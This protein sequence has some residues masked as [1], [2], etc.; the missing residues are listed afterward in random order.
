MEPRKPAGSKRKSATPRSSQKSRRASPSPKRKAVATPDSPPVDLGVGDLPPATERDLQRLA[1]AVEEDD[2]SERAHLA[3]QRR[4]K[5]CL[6]LLDLG[7]SYSR[8]MEQIQEEF[9]VVQRTAERDLARAYEAIA[10]EEGDELPQRAARVSRGVWRVTHKAEQAQDW[11]AAIAG[12]KQL[13]SFYGMDAPKKVQ[14]SGGI[15]PEQ[16][17]LLDALQLTPT[18]RLKRIEELSGDLVASGDQS[19]PD[20]PLH[21]VD[22]QEDRDA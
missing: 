10:K 22:Q 6:A 21:E 2:G 1:A 7:L 20:G 13:A 19:G 18:E 16:Q 4:V 5:R 3:I 15:S 9:G 17:A 11:K 14:L 12:Y 8:T